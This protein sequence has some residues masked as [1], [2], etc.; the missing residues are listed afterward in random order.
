[1]RP[2]GDGTACAEQTELEVIVERRGLCGLQGSR[3]APAQGGVAGN[4]R[5]NVRGE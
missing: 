4:M 5:G 3:R 1:V 2:A